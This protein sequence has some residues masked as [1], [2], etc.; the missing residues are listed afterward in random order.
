L[1]PP[2]S[3]NLDVQLHLIAQARKR[4]VEGAVK[5]IPASRCASDSDNLPYV[6]PKGIDPDLLQKLVQPVSPAA[7]SVNDGVLFVEEFE[8]RPVAIC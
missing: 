6:R 4:A 3:L 2:E 8:N 5:F 1:S 7:L